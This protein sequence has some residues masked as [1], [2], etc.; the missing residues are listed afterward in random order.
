M[1]DIRVR[2]VI[3]ILVALSGALLNM[4][5]IFNLGKIFLNPAANPATKEILISPIALELGWMVMLIW[6]VFKPFERRHILLF[7]VIPVLCANVMHDISME[8]M[9][10]TGALL[11]NL[12]F[13]LAYAGLFVFAYFLGSPRQIEST[14]GKFH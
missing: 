14:G 5:Y 2:M 10:S 8:K 9:M 1:K 7:T 6:V 11:V 12:F 4:L 13:G 3:I